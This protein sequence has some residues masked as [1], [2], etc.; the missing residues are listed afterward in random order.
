[1]HLSPSNNYNVSHKGKSSDAHHEFIPPFEFYMLYHLC[2][3][4]SRVTATV[5]YNLFPHCRFGAHLVRRCSITIFQRLRKIQ[6]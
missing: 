5:V 2:S 6:G 1:M 4:I 3:S